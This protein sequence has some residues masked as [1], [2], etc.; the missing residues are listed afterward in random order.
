MGALDRR[1]GILFVIFVALLSIAVLRAGYLG[2]VR[3]GSLQHAAVTQQVT[4]VTIPAERGS[5][6]DRNGVELAISESADD[7]AADP[8]LVKDPLG[9]AQKL[10]PLLGKPVSTL[11]TLLNRKHTGFVYLAHLVPGDRIAQINKLHLEGL[12]TLP[13]VRRVYPR[14]WAAS[15]VLGTVGWDDQGLSGLEYRYNNDLRGRDGQR[16]IVNDAL[17]QAISI[18]DVRPTVPGQTLRLTIDSALQGEVE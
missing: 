1:I 9:T 14:S 7:L 10:A 4:K 15:H 6:T 8:Y 16:R 12:T 3:A 5:I 2:A 18:D 11:L 13:Q 17:G